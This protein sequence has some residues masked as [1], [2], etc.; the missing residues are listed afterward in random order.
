MTTQ[1]QRSRRAHRPAFSLLELTLVLVILGVLG[2]VAA[3]NILGVGER[4][5]VSATKTSM[6][7]IDGA[8]KDYMLNN[9]A[10]PPTLQELVDKKFL[11]PKSLKDAWKREW[12]YRESD[13]TG[14]TYV[15]IS[16]GAN[17]DDPADDIDIVQVRNE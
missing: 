9:G 3:V 7:V 4:A 15:L 12:Y 2:A 11:E 16:L 1:T 5:K 10:P 6:G 17:P 13:S 8:I 14:A